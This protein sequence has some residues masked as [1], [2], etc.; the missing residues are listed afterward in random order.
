M[1]RKSWILGAFETLE[2]E[3][4]CCMDL[5]QWMLD[6]FYNENSTDRDDSKWRPVRRIQL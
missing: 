5:K 1:Y 4:K 3:Y 2:P 6:D